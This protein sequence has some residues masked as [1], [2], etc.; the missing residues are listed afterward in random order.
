MKI[1]LLILVCFFP[2]AIFSQNFPT[3][4]TKFFP[5]DTMGIK[6]TLTLKTAGVK[7]KANKSSVSGVYTAI[8]KTASVSDGISSETI[9][10]TPD[11][12]A[13]DA[14]KRVSGVTIQN[15]KFVI[16]RGLP[17]RYNSALLDHLF[18]SSTEPDR[19]SFSFDIVPSNLIDNIMIYKSASANRWILLLR[20][21]S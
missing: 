15:N 11:A 12:T 2:L 16:V 9:K 20:N 19:R 21:Y 18:V 10:K 14:L 3:D 7:V 8:R 4:T 17:D 1:K 6:D 13:S 5:I